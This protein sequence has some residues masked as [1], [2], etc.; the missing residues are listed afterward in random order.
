MKKL[1]EKS[2]FT[3][4]VGVGLTLTLFLLN[5]WILSIPL[6]WPFD[7]E[8]IL[9]L[10]MFVFD[11]GVLYIF[12]FILKLV[13]FGLLIPVVL[14]GLSF[15][16]KKNWGFLLAALLNLGFAV[17]LIAF[18]TLS[19]YLPILASVLIV[20]N[21]LLSLVLF[22]VILI[23]RKTIEMATI[24]SKEAIRNS[25]SKIPL[26]VI[27]VDILAVAIYLTTFFIPL[28]TDI[29]AGPDYNAVLINILF[30]EDTHT[31][32][33]IGFFV[34]FLVFLGVFLY[35]AEVMS[36]YI[37]S[38]DKFMR[39]SKRLV[40]LT[41][42]ATSVFFLAGL[43]ID[44]IYTVLWESDITIITYLPMLM[45]FVVVF[46]YAI[47]LGRYKGLQQVLS[48]AETKYANIEGLLYVAIL[49]A[50]TVLTLFLPIVKI[51]VTSGAYSYPI[52]MTGFDL[53]KD[54][55]SFDP[56]YRIVAYL[57]YVM[58]ISVGFSLIVTITSF[59]SKSKVF[60][61]LVKFSTIVNVFF[62]FLIGI[63]GYYFQIAKE[64]NQAIILD[65]A[66][67]Y[68]YTIINLTN[69]DYV[70]GTDTIYMLLG[71]LFVVI[72]MFVRKVFDREP[73]G[74]LETGAL[75]NSVSGN[76]ISEETTIQVFDPCYSFTELDSQREEFH[77]D[78]DKRKKMKPEK[79]TLNG[80][81]NFIVEYARNSRLH[82]SY[83]PEDIA[84]FVAGLGASRLTVLQG[85]SGTGKTSLPKI[86][87][88]AIYGN[89]EIVEVESSWKDKN[90]LLG[91]YNEFSLK[92]TPK[93]FT[94]AL[95]KAAL[96][97]D[98]FTFILLDEM[99]LSRIEYYFSDFLSLMENEEDKRR[100]KLVNIKLTKQ[101][102]DN[103]VEY[104]ALEHGHTLKVPANV[105]FVGTA[106]RDESTF[107]ISDKV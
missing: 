100:I 88:E 47:L 71:S 104:S 76:Q 87:S 7:S 81:V 96:N 37:I 91:Y 102:K 12:A 30:A 68:G 32:L 34:N 107:V 98:I 8:D 3:G 101:D 92:Y 78:L 56:G 40:M 28:Y 84:T 26:L 83:T 55:A 61:S 85:M 53:L 80:L 44:I 99:N 45:S 70:V 73:S 16:Q 5:L 79:P 21:I 74:L 82:L 95:Y 4:L 39:Q 72:I 23:R 51:D 46:L 66:D 14:S 57:L 90:E 24:A 62:V 105:W 15:F 17:A 2:W 75:G 18:Q 41:F 10:P 60:H 67:H 58:L 22:I 25:I 86:F 11:E 1:L 93:K 33:I 52:H 63:S 48:K 94:L 64:I 20:I 103:E 29:V 49:T 43:A 13:F 19:G 38:K 77:R 36:S 89:C 106:N 42:I 97:Q 54:Y 69:F 50:I 27:F 59:V 9:H 65:L 31:V 35:F 6:T